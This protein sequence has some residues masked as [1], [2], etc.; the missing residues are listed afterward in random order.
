MGL[1]PVLSASLNSSAM[2]GL[3]ARPPSSA[4]PEYPHSDADDVPPSPLTRRPDNSESRKGLGCSGAWRTRL[5]SVRPESGGDVHRRVDPAVGDRPAAQHRLDRSGA[6]MRTGSSPRPT[7]CPLAGK[8]GDV[9][10]ALSPRAG[11]AARRNEAL[12]RQVRGDREGQEGEARPARLVS[13]RA[14]AWLWKISAC[15]SSGSPRLRVTPGIH[16]PPGGRG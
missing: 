14:A 1:L 15:R 12:G 11:T 16:R 2:R 5:D 10:G 8:G 13:S 4:N 9:P 3:P 6:V 7:A